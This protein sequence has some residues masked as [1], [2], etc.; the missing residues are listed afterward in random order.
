MSTVT[1]LCSISAEV[2]KKLAKRGIKT[3]TGLGRYYRNIDN[4]GT[5]VLYRFELEKGL[6]TFRIELP[7]EV[8]IYLRNECLFF[9]VHGE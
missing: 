9:W 3:Y 6:F 4:S 7:P 8:M 1:E 2:Q 5:G